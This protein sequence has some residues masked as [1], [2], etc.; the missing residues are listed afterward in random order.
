M[1]YRLIILS[2][3]R[4]G[5]QVTVPEEPLT[6]GRSPDSALHLNDT[7][8]AMAHAVVEHRMNS[9]VIHDLGSMNKIL[10]NSTGVS[11]A[12]LKHGDV[13]EIGRTRLL[14]QAFVQAEVHSPP[15]WLPRRKALRVAVAAAL[16]LV[17]VALA[18]PRLMRRAPEPG[19]PPDNTGARVPVVAPAV[20]PAL[21]MASAEEPLMTAP[22]MPPVTEPA[23]PPEPAA[24]T[25]AAAVVEATAAT[26]EEL[27][28]A[29]APPPPVVEPPA[30]DTTT[31][32]QAAAAMLT[33]KV[34]SMMAEALAT[35]SNSTPAKAEEILRS[36]LVINPDYLP[37][38]AERARLF[39]GRGLLDPAIEQWQEVIRRGAG[40]PIAEEAS[41]MCRRLGRAREAK[42]PDY[43]NQINIAGAEQSKF[44]E[45]RGFREM[46]AISVTLR[47]GVRSLLP[48]ADAVRVEVRFYDR[49]KD[50]GAIIASEAAVPGDRLTV[51]GPWRQGEEKIVTATYAVPAGESAAATKA[52][53]FYGYVVRVYYYGA[54]QDEYA[55]PRALLEAPKAWATPPP[56]MTRGPEEVGLAS[57]NPS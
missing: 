55:Q 33:Q 51:A 50:T 16:A 21:R 46:R 45:T 43:A 9:L 4:K 44:P 41:G 57:R 30:P 2:G 39:A 25:S 17:A 24:A 52:G 3:D 20:E 38:Y 5:Q 19:A 29:S 49:K 14:V 8:I 54:L 1:L 10:V 32:T 18:M 42:V 12:H 53:Q 34:Q 23:T 36:V 6:I 7:E 22:A 13:I 11:R 31:V 35:A 47:P 15:R 56:V 28:V 37:A 48:D 26:N 40:T 27:L